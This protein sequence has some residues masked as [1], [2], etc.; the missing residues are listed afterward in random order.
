[1]I[2]EETCPTP[3]I[4][5]SAITLMLSRA[6][7]GAEQSSPRLDN[8]TAT[9]D[10]LFSTSQFA[11][12]VAGSGTHIH[13]HRLAWNAL[14]YGRKQWYLFRPHD[15][16]MSNQH[17]LDFLS[18]TTKDTLVDSDGRPVPSWTCTQS[19]GDVVIVPEGWAHGV[20][21]I[22]ES[23]AVATELRHDIWRRPHDSTTA[24]AMPMRSAQ[25][26]S[27]S[28]RIKAVMA[29]IST[30]C[31]Q[32]PPRGYAYTTT[33]KLIIDPSVTGSRASSSSSSDSGTAIL[34]FTTEELSTLELPR[35]PIGIIYTSQG[36]LQLSELSDGAADQGSQQDNGHS[37]VP[38]IASL[39]A[40][41][42]LMMARHQ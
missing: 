26:Q 16:L 21:N 15:R 18:P 14:V 41:Q 31:I 5:S 11:I 7:V 1:L 37:D 24:G 20:V 29:E 23:I 4:I 35:P 3:E 22:Q 2:D 13:Y 32:P 40:F 6:R 27:E 10:D 9:V 17:I 42:R 19:A 38:T 34:E 36:S 12:G 30:K 28:N 25:D 33:G 39:L 8:I